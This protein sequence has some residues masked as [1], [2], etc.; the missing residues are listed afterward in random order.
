MKKIFFFCLVGLC[1]CTQNQ[2]L[3]EISDNE[4]KS[5]EVSILPSENEIE[6]RL[7]VTSALKYLWELNDTIGIFP[8]KGGQVEFP[9]EAESVGNSKA[10]FNGGGWALKGG[11]T[12]SAYYPFN[13][14]N[15][16]ATKIPFSYEGQVL[17][18]KDN[19]KHLSNYALMISNPTTVENG[20]LVFSMKHVGCMFQLN[21]TMP[22]AKTYSSLD[23]YADSEIIPVKKYFNILKSGAPSEILACSSHLSVVLKN[24]QTTSANEKIV[25]WVAFPTMNQP[26]KTLK[27]VVKDSQGY[28]Y[29]G[30]V[31]R[32]NP[33]KT[34]GSYD[35]F[36]NLNTGG[37][38]LKASPVLTDGFTGGIEDWIKDENVYTGN[39][40]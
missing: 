14:Y 29:V 28:V 33:D 32:L 39:A 3:E 12:Y 7:E 9:V 18:G 34:T 40:Y 8:N 15:R 4:I 1:S 6:S 30:D 5:V 11:Y 35:F 26:A 38:Q 37:Y 17:Q 23:L 21:L 27:V 10:D 24:V 36:L 20:Q 16:N 13:F 25:L 19:R 2:N 31:S 22:E